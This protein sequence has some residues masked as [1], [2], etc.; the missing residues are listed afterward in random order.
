MHDHVHAD[1]NTDELFLNAG[2]KDG[3]WHSAEQYQ[4]FFH[5]VRVSGVVIWSSSHMFLIM[6]L[7]YDWIPLILTR[8]VPVLLAS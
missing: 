7:D 1:Y 8:V 6:I 4:V 2:I 5:L 3:E